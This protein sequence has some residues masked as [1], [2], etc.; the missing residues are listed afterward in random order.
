MDDADPVR[1]QDMIPKSALILGLAGTIPFIFST[2]LIVWPERFMPYFGIFVFSGPLILAGYGRVVLSF[3]SGVLWGFATKAN[4]KAAA[5]AYAAS[6]VPALYV[7]IATS[8]GTTFVLVPLAIGFV[9]ILVFDYAFARA[10][11]A[12]H[13]WMKLRLIITT[14]VLVCFFFAIRASS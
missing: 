7:F 9:G 8:L 10:G 6:V 5:F 3:M 13:W 1:K 2:L 12:P 4:G 11:L 14:I